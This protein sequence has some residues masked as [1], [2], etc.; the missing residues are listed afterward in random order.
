MAKRKPSE[1]EQ[2]VLGVVWKEGA[3]T[4]HTVRT[5]FADSRNSRFSGSA[6]AI[7][8]LVERLER[9][10]LLRSTSDRTTRQRRRLYR[11]TEKGLA[12]LR[13]WVGSELPFGIPHDPIRLRLYFLEALAPS[14]RAKFLDAAERGMRAELGFL[15]DDRDRYEREGWTY[16]VCATD[17]A[18]AIVR[19]QIAWLGRLRRGGPTSKRAKTS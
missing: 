9:R 15:R 4:P 12:E 6:G 2:V 13:A 19:A 8:P 14:A 16:S 11:I 17:G 3:C 18:I 10:G 1:L 7:Y 5:H